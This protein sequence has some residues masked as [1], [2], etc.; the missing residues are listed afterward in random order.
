MNMGID[1]YNTFE[2]HKKVY[3]STLE[4]LSAGE[5]YTLTKINSIANNLQQQIHDLCDDY[6]HLPQMAIGTQQHWMATMG[7]KTWDTTLAMDVCTH[8]D[9]PNVGP[10][11]NQGLPP[12]AQLFGPIPH[13]TPT[14]SPLNQSRPCALNR[15]IQDTS[16]DVKH[17]HGGGHP[18]Y[19]LDEIE[20]LSDDNLTSLGMDDK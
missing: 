2:Q 17:W 9:I 8:R 19:A 11:A 6:R 10:C 1:A 5:S 16:L 12:I 3:E 4:D 15:L 7:Q 18:E 14:V 13:P 20:E